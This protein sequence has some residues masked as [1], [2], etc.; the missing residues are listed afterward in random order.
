MES[1]SSFSGLMRGAAWIYVFSR[2]CLE[3][4]YIYAMLVGIEWELPQCIE[5]RA[6]GSVEGR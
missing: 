4:V 6:D 3:C 5:G 2:G 1:Y